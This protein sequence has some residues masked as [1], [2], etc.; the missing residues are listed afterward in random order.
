MAAAE[1]AI[2]SSQRCAPN[3]VDIPIA[4]WPTTAQDK[5][6]DAKRVSQQIIDSLNSFLD[7]KEY[8]SVGS[9]FVE[10]GY[11][12]DH[13]ALTWDLRTLK[14]RQKMCSFLASGTYLR[15]IQIDYSDSDH[16][17][18]M[19]KLRADG[20]IEGILFFTVVTTEHGSG[21]GVT[22]LVEED[23]QWKIWTMFTSLDELRGHEEKLGSNRDNGVQHGATKDRKNWAERRMEESNFE[24]TDPDV[25]IIGK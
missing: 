13:L 7:K 14:G 10:D 2:P 16:A 19:S 23:G 8:E 24:K 21:R 18:Q 9:L 20:S 15:H 6:V 1:V 11:W 17:P 4:T 3:S 5:S 25:L 22:R 12:R